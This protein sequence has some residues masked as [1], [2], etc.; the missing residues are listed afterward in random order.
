MIIVTACRCLVLLR[1]RGVGV[2]RS[3]GCGVGILLSRLRLRWY[4]LRIYGRFLILDR[5]YLMSANRANR[6]VF[7]VKAAVCTF[8][9]ITSRNLY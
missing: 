8:H 6:V 1:R 4:I 9:K 3:G 5:R 7:G 2:L